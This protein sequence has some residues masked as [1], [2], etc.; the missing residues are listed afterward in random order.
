MQEIKTTAKCI[1]CHLEQGNNC[2]RGKNKTCNECLKKR[3]PMHIKD[4][5]ECESLYICAKLGHIDC[6][7]DIPIDQILIEDSYSRSMLYY[8]MICNKSG[9]IA[10]WMI[11]SEHKLEFQTDQII[12]ISNDYLRRAIRLYNSLDISK[13]HTISED[14]ILKQA[15]ICEAN[16]YFYM[17]TLINGN[18]FGKKYVKHGYEK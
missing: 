3:K 15:R 5:T 18:G 6:F 8:A 1:V 4:T 13:R 17:Q 2:F 12:C 10:Y 7:T 16:Q 9:L 11:K 14:L